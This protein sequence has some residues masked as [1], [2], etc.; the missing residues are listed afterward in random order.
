MKGNVLYQTCIRRKNT[1]FIPNLGWF[2]VWGQREENMN[3]RKKINF[4]VI[5]AISNKRNAA[6]I[7]TTKTNKT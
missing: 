4:A 3:W 7:K 1:F 5:F 2:D 6:K